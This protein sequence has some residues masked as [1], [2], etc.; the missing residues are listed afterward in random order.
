MTMKL[1][2]SNDLSIASPSPVQV[3]VAKN[4]H[5]DLF[6]AYLDSEQ[7][8]LVIQMLIIVTFVLIADDFKWSSN[9]HA[10]SIGHHAQTCRA[11]D[12]PF[13]NYKVCTNSIAKSTLDQK[14]KFQ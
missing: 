8:F 6:D 11:G 4:F 12:L 13:D 1:T 3:P 7:R 14:A 10:M 9:E 2:L 5:N